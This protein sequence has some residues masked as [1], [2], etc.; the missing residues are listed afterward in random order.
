[1]HTYSA[2]I[3]WT[4][5]GSAFTDQRYSR[6]HTWGFDGGLQVP[7]SS[8][9]LSVPVPMSN[10]ANIDPEEALV[11][12]TSSCHLLWFLHIAATA[13]FVVDDYRDDAA[14]EMHRNDKGK[15]AITRITLRPRIVFAGRQPSAD[16]LDALHHK[17]H[18]E[19]YIA[20]SI[21]AD[22][23]IEAGI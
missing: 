9:P 16:E 20:N 14:G 11:A 4:R 17:A 12:A 15:L 2:A 19:C 1:M 6:A 22:V 8:S 13:G 21:K 23:I 7:A 18:E 10:P 5:D 3:A